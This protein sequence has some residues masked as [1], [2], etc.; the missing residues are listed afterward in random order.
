MPATAIVSYDG[1]ANDADALTLARVLGE[2]GA[3]L[4]LAYVLHSAQ[5]PE[6][7]AA[8]ALL[9]RGAALLGDTDAETR[10]VAH[11][12]TSDGLGRLAAREGA[13]LIVFGSAY[14]TPVGRV[15][16]QTSTQRLLDGGS[17][18][19]AIAPAGY[20][21]REIRT[22]GLLAGLDDVAAIDTAHA[23]ATHYSA[24]VTDHGQGVDLLIVGSRPQAR[25]GTTLLC[26]RSESAIF[27]A[28]APVLVTARGVA[29]DFRTELYLA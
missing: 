1:T 9:R 14:R 24:A 16:P 27:D 4:L 6:A 29:L 8:R 18:A 13:A 7:D 23:L 11:P 20:D 12:S 17:T 10:L 26:A 19:L 22:I 28:T 15:A 25:T 21:G 3:R 2:A 5:A